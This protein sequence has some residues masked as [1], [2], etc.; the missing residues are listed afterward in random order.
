MN[1]EILGAVGLWGIRGRRN[2]L[3][4]YSLVGFGVSGVEPVGTAVAWFTNL[5]LVC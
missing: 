4:L 1:R 3:G 2:S 5:Q